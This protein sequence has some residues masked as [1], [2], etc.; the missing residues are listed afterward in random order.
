MAKLL[1]F[2]NPSTLQE[3][4][5]QLIVEYLVGKEFDEFIC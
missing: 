4:L 3:H 5:L 1:W 2:L